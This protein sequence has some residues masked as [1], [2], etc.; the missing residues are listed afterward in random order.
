MKIFHKNKYISYH[1]HFEILKIFIFN[2]N[3]QDTKMN[4]KKNYI[5]NTKIL[6]NMN[7]LKF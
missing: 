5:E 6:K 7:G 3:Y 4:K 2:I 1:F